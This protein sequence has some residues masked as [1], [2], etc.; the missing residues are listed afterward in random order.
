MGD[1]R[2]EKFDPAVPKFGVP[3]PLRVALLATLGLAAFLLVEA[4]DLLEAKVARQTVRSAPAYHPALAAL[5]AAGSAVH[6]APED[7][8]LAFALQPG[9]NLSTVL[10][11]L[12]LEGHEV[13]TVTEALRGYVDLRRLRAGDL[14]VAYFDR[15]SQLQT[16][17]MMVADRG[18]V[19]ASRRSGDWEVSW[20]P[21]ERTVRVANLRGE[22]S[23][24]LETSIR[25]AGGQAGVAYLMA[26]ALQWD[27]DFNRDLRLGDHFEVLYEEVYLDGRYHGLGR[28]LAMSYENGGRRLEAY[29][30]G[31]TDGFYD[32]EG[33]PLWKMF[34]RSPLRYSRVTS[35]F[36][37]RRFHPV[38]KTYRP[39][40]GVDYGAPVGTPVRVTASGVV[41]F[42][43]WDRGG[44]KTVKVRHP[45]EYE[46]AYL[47]LSRFGE[48][49]RSGQRV[50][51]GQVIG[52]V[53]A[54]GL[55]TGPHLDYRVKHRGSWLN[56]LNIKSM[57]ADPIAQRDMPAFLAWRDSLRRSLTSG[58]APNLEGLERKLSAKVQVAAAE[59][60][61]S[62]SAEQT[63]R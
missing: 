17:Q 47:H 60:S 18:T 4:T 9:E 28:V 27:L 56:P 15:S 58:E 37:Q 55:A 34:L 23:G 7:T 16:Y 2:S 33:R 1:G 21:F 30:F 39:H 62:A 63:T 44:G 51:Q 54:T 14:Y 53:G 49:I 59:G 12:G 42:A 41:T 52:Y 40:Y 11:K 29:R 6:L 3:L 8:P 24:A 20:Q 61:S 32:G 22:L 19:T 50:Q 35:G 57:P 25:Q 46:T 36:S 31:D 13:R 45:N 38:L 5:S 26:D 10:T 48:G 43:G